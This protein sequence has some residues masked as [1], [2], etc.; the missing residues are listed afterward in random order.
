[1]GLAAVAPK[2]ATASA[3]RAGCRVAMTGAPLRRGWPQESGA[4]VKGAPTL[5]VAVCAESDARLRKSIAQI[6][7]KEYCDRAAISQQ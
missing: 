1:M 2:G 6:A 3:H 4:R 7:R 5:T